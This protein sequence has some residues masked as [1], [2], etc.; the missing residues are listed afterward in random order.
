MVSCV[1]C[2][3]ASG[4]NL[5]KNAQECGS[6]SKWTWRAGEESVDGPWVQK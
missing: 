2:V 3:K 6:N 1:T 4:F 5:S